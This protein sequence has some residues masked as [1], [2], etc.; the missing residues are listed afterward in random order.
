MRAMKDSGIEWIGQI[1]QAWSVG[2][3][4]FGLEMPITDGPHE[5]PQLYSEGIPFVSAEAVSTGNGRINFEN[6]RGYISQEYYEE[7]CKKYIPQKEDIYMIKSGATTGKIAIV[8]TDDVFTIWSPLAVFRCNKERCISRF[9]FYTLQSDYYQKQLESKWSFGTQQN[10][11]MRTLE[12]LLI[13]YPAVPEQERIVDYLDA[14]CAAIDALIAA[15]EKTNA[16]LKERRQ[17]IIYEAVTKG[18]NPD[19]PMK[20]SGIEWIGQIPERWSVWRMKH[21]ASEPLQYGANATGV[22]F[23]DDIPRYVRITDISADRKLCYEGKQSL[24][25]D[26]AQDYMLDDGDILFARSGATSGKSFY[27]ESEYGP[28][29]F[30]GYLIKLRTDKSKALSKFLYYYT[31]TQAYENWTQQIFIQ[32]TIQNI[33]ADKYNNLWFAIPETL[34]EQAYIV[35]YLDQ[36]CSEMDALITANEKTI[37]KLKE[38]RQSI[39]YE[40]VTGKIEI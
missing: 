4:I 36:R 29:C 37:K 12:R 27:Y 21:L 16:L 30:A 33:S 26:I 9:L 34:E 40:A 28:C 1:P 15:K 39:I 31:L 10:I 25:T 32:A 2:K 7:C 8:D 19:A 23:R 38:Y 11:G 17:S 22:E 20:D 6:I 3:T 13:C 35:A 5:T 14:K 18:L 24:E